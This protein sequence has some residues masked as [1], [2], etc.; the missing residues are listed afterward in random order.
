[1]NNDEKAKLNKNEGIKYFFPYWGPFVFVS[2]IEDEFVDLLLKRGK[3]S[4]KKRLNATSVL[5]G[6]I[7]NEY[8]YENF[9]WFLP[10]FNPY[11]NAYCEG[12]THYGL[13]SRPSN[14]EFDWKSP[15]KCHLEHLWINFQQ[16]KE[17]N[18]PHAHSG[19][20]SFVIYLQVPDEIEKEKEEMQGVHNHPGPGVIVFD[21]GEDLKFS[22]SRWTFMPQASDIII[23]PA[24]L[25]HHV[26]S[27]ESDV[28]RISVS[29]NIIINDE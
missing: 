14:H 29:G 23:F 12:M 25:K 20:I 24:W 5:A 28:E 10:K 18:P 6:Q 1:M 27:F 3:Q 19:D 13:D 4:K 2:K 11:F 8:N 7:K 16:A 17:Y 22:A 21:H 26:H 9:E 15:K